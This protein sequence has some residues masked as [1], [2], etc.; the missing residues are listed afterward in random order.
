MGISATEKMIIDA[1]KSLTAAMKLYDKFVDKSVVPVI[2]EFGGL[3][4]IMRWIGDVER[5]SDPGSFP[6]LFKF[7]P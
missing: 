4:G 3:L 2:N 7:R 5:L 6:G 1:E